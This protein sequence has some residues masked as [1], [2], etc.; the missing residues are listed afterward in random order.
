ML[1][2]CEW[3]LAIYF[4]YTSLLA[5]IL[6]LQFNT[7]IEALTANAIGLGIYVVL[8]FWQQRSPRAWHAVTRDWMVIAYLLLAYKQMGWFA[9]PIVEHRLEQ[10]WIQIDR[11]VL[12]NWGL[13]HAI[14]STGVVLPGLLELAYVLVY[15]VPVFILAMLYGNGRR[16]RSDSLMTIY[17]LGLLLSYGQFP[18]W[19]SEPPRTL[20]PAEDMPAIVTAIRQFSLAVV[21]SYGI[22]T[23]V[24]P[25]A[26]VSGAFGAAWA[27]KHVLADRPLLWGGM[28][29]YAVLIA[30][31]TI[32]GRYHFVVDS[33]AGV[34]VGT[35]AYFAGRWILRW[36][37][38]SDQL[39]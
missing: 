35:V 3:V 31:S 19:P 33:L 2:A 38:G 16:E 8:L 18:Y 17:S 27:L 30:V 13:K 34:V 32:Y 22:H 6:P 28:F 36:R 11:L 15:A 37:Y 26:H 21:G 25:S 12:R 4:A 10:Q 20:W 23:S 7:R 24:F 14:E 9:R 1:R 5:L 39:V 29:V